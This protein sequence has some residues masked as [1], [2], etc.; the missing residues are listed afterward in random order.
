MVDRSDIT[1]HDLS[2]DT[3]EIRVKIRNEGLERS[4]P[5]VMRLESAPFGAF[6]A[7]RPLAE[8]PVSP[9]EPGESREL[10]VVAARSHPATLGDFDGVPP[11]RVLTALSAAPDEPASQTKM[12][13]MVELLRQQ[14]ISRAQNKSTTARV[15]FP[16]F[17]PPDLWELVGREQPYWAGNINV[18]V[19]NRAVE[20]HVARALRIYAGRP[21]LAMFVVGSGGVREAYSFSLAGLDR[22][23]KAALYDRTS[24]RT[25]VA[26]ASDA[27][28]Q[29][30]QWVE[31]SAGFMLV[32]LAVRPPAVCENGNVE[33]HVTRR[34]SQETAIVE[35]NLDPTAKGP[36]C[37][38]A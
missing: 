4:T 10:S 27:L 29:E 5:T 28:V 36:G 35:F 2:R 20:R 18:F 7:W 23:W 17:L 1:F 33:V 19:G 38:V 8:L 9:L 31:A 14:A 25:L 21:N 11:M 15:A 37:Y 12:L 13:S 30:K 26:H 34:S 3:V 16:S 24:L 6:V 32:V 22:D